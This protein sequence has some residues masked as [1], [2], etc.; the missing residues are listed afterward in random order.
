MEKLKDKVIIITGAA[1]GLGLATA[2]EAVKNGAILSLIDLNEASLIQAQELILKEYPESKLLTISGDVGDLATS[3]RYTEETMKAF[4]RI[5][6]L[7]NNAGIIGGTTS[8]DEFD[9]EAFNK[10]VNINLNG[11]FYGLKS[12]IPIMKKQQYGRIVNAA[13]VGGLRGV[14]NSAAYVATKHAVVGLTKTAAAEVASSGV[15]VNAIAPGA[16][17]TSMMR[18]FFEQTNPENPQQAESEFAKNNPSK[19]L[20]LPEEVAKLVVFLL[21]E[22]CSYVNGQVIAIDGG[23][24]NTYLT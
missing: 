8:I 21:S 18:G 16:I 13:S 15:A 24:S 9:P 3:V 22:D 20:G 10:T 6:G 19:R 14:L 4:G 11:V 5:D 1:D 12:V 17:K 7:Y 23:Q 2:L